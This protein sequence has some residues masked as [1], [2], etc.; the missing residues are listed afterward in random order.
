MAKESKENIEW[1]IKHALEMK[2]KARERGDMESVNQLADYLRLLYK[3]LTS[4]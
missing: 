3:E 1:R 2:N 4:D